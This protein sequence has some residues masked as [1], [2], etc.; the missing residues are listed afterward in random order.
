MNDDLNECWIALNTLPNR[1]EQDTIQAELEL[2]GAVRVRFSWR[3]G[4]WPFV[5]FY[6]TLTVEES[7]E[8]ALDVISRR[9]P[10]LLVRNEVH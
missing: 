10:R 6:S 4:E 8:L 3:I 9:S 1:G 2:N 7:V 5:Q